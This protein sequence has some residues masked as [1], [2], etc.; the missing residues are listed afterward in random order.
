[1]LCVSTSAQAFRPYPICFGRSVSGRRWERGNCRVVQVHGGRWWRV[2]ASGGSTLVA[3]SICARA[4]LRD[5][6]TDG[7]DG[8]PGLPS[9][10]ATRRVTGVSGTGRSRA[11]NWRWSTIRAVRSPP[12][13]LGEIRARGPNI[14]LGYWRDPDNR[15]REILRD[16][17][18]HT[19][20]LATRGRSRSD[21]CSREARARSS[22]VA[23][24]RIHPREIEEFVLANCSNPGS[25]RRPLQITRKPSEVRLALFFRTDRRTSRDRLPPSQTC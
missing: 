12:A 15:R 1:M 5:V 13:R 18:L 14:M 17:W 16:G 4:I 11:L 21:L 6:W 7:S 3:R 2:A 19:G 10:R 9:P 24:Y 20:D 25:G 23:G 22:R 8:A